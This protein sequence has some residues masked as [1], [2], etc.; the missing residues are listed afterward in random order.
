MTD[1][2]VS[3]LPF[4][5]TIHLNCPLTPDDAS[6]IQST[7]WAM[8]YTWDALSLLWVILVLLVLLSLWPLTIYLKCRVEVL[9]SFEALNL[10]S[11]PVLDA[12]KISLKSI[13]TYFTFH[14]M[15]DMQNIKEEIHANYWSKNSCKLT[16]CFFYI[17]TSKGQISKWTAHHMKVPFP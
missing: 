11:Y 5:C 14:N 9:I 10:R 12:S 4:I 2:Y 17:E 7:N 3:W 16:L 13:Q 15:A 1:S 8:W 6:P